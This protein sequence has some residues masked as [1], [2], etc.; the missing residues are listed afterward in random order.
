MSS[1][2]DE[3]AEEA[4]SIEAIYGEDVEIDQAAYRVGIAFGLGFRLEAAAVQLLQLQALLQLQGLWRRQSQV[5]IVCRRC[6]MQVYLPNR[7]AETRAVLR[8]LLPDTY[9]SAVG[10]VMELEAPGISEQQLAAAVKHME[11]MFCPGEHR[12]SQNMHNSHLQGG[13]ACA[14][15][16]LFIA[17]A[18]TVQVG[19]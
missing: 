16:I 13:N 15:Y 18:T 1:D 4:A 9:P 2:A 17:S 6:L 3:Q 11:E 5:T 8:V 7:C 10:P 19:P 12:S 14:T